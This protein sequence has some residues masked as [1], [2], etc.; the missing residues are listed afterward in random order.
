[1]AAPSPIDIQDPV[2]RLSVVIDGQVLEEY[3]PVLSLEITHEI[4]RISTAEL[5]IIFEDIVAEDA[6]LKEDTKFKPGSTIEIKA[7]YGT[8]QAEAPH[9]Q[10]SYPEKKDKSKAGRVLYHG[11][12]LLT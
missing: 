8:D 11:G 10:R 6:S 12:Q 4:N 2:L 9:L 3:Y 7:A 5:S 1:M